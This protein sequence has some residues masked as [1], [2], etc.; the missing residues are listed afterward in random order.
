MP[1]RIAFLLAGALL[2][3]PSLAQSPV[4]RVSGA[5]PSAFEDCR[6]K[7]AGDIVQHTTR[8]G[9]VS[10]VCVQTPEGLVA[11]PGESR[12]VSPSQ[13]KSPVSTTG[14]SL[15]S[16]AAVDGDPLPVE[17]SCDGAGASPALQWS[18]TP[19]GTQELVLMVTT[20]P[21]DGS[22]RWNWVLFG[23][24]GTAK[25]LPRNTR[26][27]GILGATS[28]D[29]SVRYEPPCPN[30]P[31]AKRYTF[32]LHALSASPALPK[33]PGQVTG[34]VLTRAIAGITLDSASFDVVY[35]RR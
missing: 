27:I 9:P 33:D 22:T 8:E 34:A 35:A 10:A 24:P 16:P 3:V 1:S 20:I 4:S 18:R 30:G 23:I 28:H 32:T 31:G 11:R 19:A 15:T 26:G 2:S 13:R 25:G 6:G 5:P 7:Q 17:Y 21:V 29:N 14:F 12:T